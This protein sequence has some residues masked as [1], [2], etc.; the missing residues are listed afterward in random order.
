[1]ISAASY[2]RANSEAESLVGRGPGSLHPEAE[3]IGRS[4]EPSHALG[5]DADTIRQFADHVDGHNSD[6]SRIKEVCIDMSGPLI[7]GVTENLTEAEITF[8]KFHVMKMLGDAIDKTRCAEAKARPELKGSRYVWLKNEE[9]LSAGGRETLASLS[10]LH[11]KTARLSAALRLPGSLC[12]TDARLG[13]T[14]AGQVE[15]L[16]YALAH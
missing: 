9:N 16:G 4:P 12:A 14:D 8:D 15:H 5:R 1:V 11:L 6:A 3:L 10:K 13:R 7:K 2:S